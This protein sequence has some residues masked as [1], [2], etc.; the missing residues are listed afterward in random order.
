[1]RIGEPEDIV[2]KAAQSCS[3]AKLSQHCTAGKPDDADITPPTKLAKVSSPLQGVV[4][5]SAASGSSAAKPA[6]SNDETASCSAAKP[7]SSKKLH[8]PEVVQPL[9]T[10]LNTTVRNHKEETAVWNPCD[11]Y[12]LEDTEAVERDQPRFLLRDVY[13]RY[14]AESCNNGEPKEIDVVYKVMQGLVA[15]FHSDMMCRPFDRNLSST[16][17]EEANSMY[18]AFCSGRTSLT[19][20]TPKKSLDLLATRWWQRNRFNYSDDQSLQNDQRYLSELGK[21]LQDNMRGPF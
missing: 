18:N 6:S 3:A 7:A 4:T 2:A 19:R 13:D 1:M 14:I 10:V 20:N 17:Q 12:D 9:L 16:R 15:L 8:I 11:V 21:L 5:T